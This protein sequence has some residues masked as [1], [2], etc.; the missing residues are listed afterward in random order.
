MNKRSVIKLIL[1][2]LILFIAFPQL[3]VEA[4]APLDHIHDYEVQVDMREDGTCDLTYHIEWEVL[5]STSEGPLTWIKVGIP[6][7][8][9]DEFEAFSD[10]IDKIKYYSSGGDYVRLD[11][12]RAYKAGE[13]LELDFSFHQAN[14]FVLDEDGAHFE[15][16]PGWF[17]DTPVDKITVRWN[18]EYVESVEGNPILSDGYYIWTNDA[19]GYDLRQTVKLVYAKDQYDYME[20]NYPEDNEGYYTL[21]QRKVL[22]V[23]IFAV[24]ILGF[25][26]VIIL[27]TKS[28]HFSA[29]G[30]TSHR[31]LGANYHRYVSTRHSS[32]SGGGCA[33]ACACACAGGG[34][35]G[36]SRK[37]F[38][39]TKLY[40]KDIYKA[41]EV[42]YS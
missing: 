30:Y 17:E 42:F 22:T 10:N 16:T 36:C 5:D 37:D 34:R 3:S 7:K 20:G 4:K 9:A 25:V 13:I 33:C 39:G 6:N 35:A 15:F 23:L 1:F 19:G 21:E 12:D 14:L 18:A 31:G 38:Y 32:H 40:T 24:P 2:L 27:I 29:D 28:K 11:L 8:H 41:I 26:I